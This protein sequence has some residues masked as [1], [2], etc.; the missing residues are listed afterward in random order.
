MEIS[1]SEYKCFNKELMENPGKSI[2]IKR[3]FNV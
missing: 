3:K 1:H 2:K